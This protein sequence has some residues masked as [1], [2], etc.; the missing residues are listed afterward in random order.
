[1]IKPLPIAMM[2]LYLTE[3]IL[4]NTT[5]NKKQ[6]MSKWV[7]FGLLFS[8]VGDVLLM[9]SSLTAF[10]VGTGFFLVAHFL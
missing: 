6:I 8:I 2:I 4:K 7:V 5:R 3:S 1:M 9:F 10:M